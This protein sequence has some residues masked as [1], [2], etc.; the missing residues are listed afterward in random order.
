MDGSAGTIEVRLLRWSDVPEYLKVVFLGIG[1]LERATGLDRTSGALIRQLSRRSTWVV[2]G[3]LRLFGRS[4]LEILIAVDGKRIA[5]TGTLI[6]LRNAGYVAAMV[7]AP[8]Y[9]GRGVAARILARLR[10]QSERRHRSSLVLDVDADNSV[11][12]S[13][14]RR[15]GYR[16]VAR[17]AWYAR[18]GPPP[19]SPAVGGPSRPATKRDLEELLAALDSARSAE[20]RV[21]L[22]A[23]VSMLSH[24]EL[25]LSGRGVRRET[26]VRRSPAGSLLVLRTCFSPEASLGIYFPMTDPAPPSAEEVAGLFDPGT[27]WLR[28]REPAACVAVVAEPVGAV[29]AA[30]EALGFARAG[31]SVTMLCPSAA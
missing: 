15:A 6:F 20:Y 14:Y 13:V 19:T 17:C 4:P 10:E 11:A 27:D 9:R 30:L 18:A 23:S 2:L 24:S 26:W 16:E 8:E 3:F 28:P 5:G 29:G 25:L 31:T 1:D 12:I 21:A 7:T 22:P